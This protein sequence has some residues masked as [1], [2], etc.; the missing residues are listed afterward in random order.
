MIRVRHAAGVTEVGAHAADVRSLLVHVLD[1]GLDG[2]GDPYGQHVGRFTGGGDEEAV[3]QLLDGELF[4]GLDVCGGGIRLDALP[5]GGTGGELLVQG[6]LAAVHGVQHQQGGHDLGDAGGIDFLVRVLLVEHRVGVQVHQQRRLG[7][8]LHA[9]QNIR[10]RVGLGHQ[11][12][13]Q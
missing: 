5:Q 11:Q 1:E 7:F 10:C 6:Q 12:G 2:A 13:E 4:A 9:A 3:E 8:D